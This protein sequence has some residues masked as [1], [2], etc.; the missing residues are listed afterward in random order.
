MPSF[1]WKQ[2]CA[3]F[4][5]VRL[6]EALCI[7][8][9]LL[10]TKLIC[11][12]SYD[13]YHRAWSL[14]CLDLLFDSPL[15]V[16]AWINTLIDMSTLGKENQTSSTA[17]CDY[18]ICKPLNQ[19]DIERGVLL[20]PPLMRRPEEIMR[21]LCVRGASETQSGNLNHSLRWKTRP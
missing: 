9:K 13:L 20:V 1:A 12:S 16:A 17:A 15:K 19:A 14:I 5:V 8:C 21:K 4:S 7:K 10:K 3:Q 2:L 11:P 18:P 6:F